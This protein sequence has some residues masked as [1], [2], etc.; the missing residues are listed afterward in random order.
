MSEKKANNYRYSFIPVYLAF[1]IDSFGLAVIYPILTPLFLLPQFALLPATTSIFQKTVLLGLGIAMF[2]IAQL[3]GAPIIGE[4]SDY[5]GRKKA[6]TISISGASVGYAIT[7]IGILFLQF[8]F[9]LLGRFISGFFAGNLTICLASLA[10]MT[11]DPAKRIRSFGRLAAFGGLSFVLGIVLGTSLSSAE[12]GSGL[13]PSIPFWLISFVSLLNLMLILLFFHPVSPSKTPA[14]FRFLQ[15]LYNVFLAFKQPQLHRL[16]LAFFFFMICWISSMQ[17][18]STFLIRIFK[19]DPNMIQIALITAGAT[20]SLTNGFISKRF[21]RPEGY[22]S[23]LHF[24]L[25]ALTCILP[26]SLL[27]KEAWKFVIFFGIATFCSALSWTLIQAT[28]SLRAGATNQGRSLGINQSIGALAG[29]V[30]PLLGGVIAGT[31]AHYLY[32]F[33]AFSA[34]LAFIIIFFDAKRQITDKP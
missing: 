31:N 18:L 17:F 8:P 5:I 32:L 25:L 27:A 2:P 16:Y 10:D 24:S 3:I 30:G 22:S 11:P 4:F 12:T 9:L 26:M 29:I 19:A 6:F 7:A 33:S 21:V 1:V 34:F 23:L 13:N 14:S 15:G 20:W 28:V